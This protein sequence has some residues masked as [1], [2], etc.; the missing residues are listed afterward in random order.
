MNKLAWINHKRKLLSDIFVNKKSAE[1]LKFNIEDQE[2]NQETENK[3]N[4]ILQSWK[5]LLHY[6]AGNNSVIEMAPTY[7]NGFQVIDDNL[8]Q[9]ILDCAINKVINYFVIQFDLEEEIAK[10]AI[11]DYISSYNLHVKGLHTIVRKL[12][13]L[14]P[15]DLP[16]LLT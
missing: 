2:N 12:K 3:S 10:L 1:V 9:K 11:I 8:G 6:S 5:D 16:D 14:Q 13:N 4:V 7:I 15:E